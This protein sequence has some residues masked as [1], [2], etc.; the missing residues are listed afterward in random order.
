MEKMNQPEDV[1]D[2]VKDMQEE[3]TEEDIEKMN[4]EFYMK[5]TEKP[6]EALEE[7]INQR[8]EAKIQPMKEYFDNM[9]KMQYWNEQISEFEKEHPDFQDYVDDISKVIQSDESIRNSKNPL[10]LAYKVIKADKLDS[11]VK[12]LDRPIE[13]RLKEDGVL[14]EILS[15][16]DIKNMLIKELKSSREE[17]PS[18]IGKDGKTSVNVE[19]KPKTIS[20]GTKAWLNS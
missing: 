14:K 9:Q 8:A 16:K 15:N 19:E 1:Q 13:E 6:L 5:F 18:V 7:L 3:L 11:K 17:T 2:E 10:E 12:E 20:D 4:N